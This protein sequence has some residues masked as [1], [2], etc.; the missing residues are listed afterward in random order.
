MEHGGAWTV[1]AILLQRDDNETL[2][3]LNDIILNSL[4]SFPSCSKIECFVH[5]EA[6]SVRPYR[7]EWTSTAVAFSYV[8]L[9]TRL[10][11]FCK[12]TFSI[13]FACP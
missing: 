2:E 13:H 10:T 8:S 5:H 9:D 4:S 3:V 11:K 6:A 1:G 12:E 7:M